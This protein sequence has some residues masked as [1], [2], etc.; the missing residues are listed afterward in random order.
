VPQPQSHLS[1]RPLEGEADHASRAVT[2]LVCPTPNGG[3]KICFVLPPT[4][5]YYPRS[6]GA[7]STVTRHL[8]GS[9]LDLGHSVDV[10][11]PDHGED[12]YAEGAVLRLRFGPASPPPKLLHKSYVLETRVRR[13]CWPEYGPYLRRVLRCLSQ[14]GVALDLVVVAN[15]PE[16]A[17]RL[18]QKGVG[19]RQVLWLHNQLRG[20]EA[21]RLSNLPP[22]VTVVAVSDAVRRWTSD[23]YG[24]PASSISVIHNG[25]DLD[26]F[27]PRDD[28]DQTRPGIRVVSHGR[29]DPNKGHEIAARAVGELRRRGYPVTFTMVGGVQTYGISDAQAAAYADELAVAIAEAEGTATGRLPASDV[30]DVLRDQDIACVLSKCAEPFSLAALEAMASGCAVIT[31]GTGG[32]GEVV[33]ESADF[34]GI[35]DVE[36]VAA[37][38]EALT[39]D[40]KLLSERKT[41]ALLRSKS[42]TWDKAASKVEALM[43]GVTS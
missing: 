4:E 25:I 27:H 1:D 14:P 29:I 28:F 9:L 36:A 6:G 8:A 12:H 39:T 32:I 22:G 33:G 41:S 21:R 23:T 5:S 16:L 30:A 2:H 7:I 11:T 40:P 31:T 42:F 10:L 13:W 34:V 38:I 35:D 26:E 17:C 15:D 19:R 24:I 20:K 3:L 43:V 18:N 37:A